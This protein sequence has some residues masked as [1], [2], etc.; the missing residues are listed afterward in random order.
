MSSPVA[1]PLSFVPPPPECCQVCA[2][3]HHEDLPHNAQSLYY[4]MTFHEDHGRW[5]TWATAL[6]HCGPD[7]RDAWRS[8]LTT[9]GAWLPEFDT[10]L[11]EYDARQAMKEVP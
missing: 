10:E 7:M 4:Q 8:A 3:K 6:A 5:P 2:V 9:R 11:A 1:R